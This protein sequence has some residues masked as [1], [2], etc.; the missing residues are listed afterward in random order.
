NRADGCS[1][2]Q[3]SQRHA[4]IATIAMLAMLIGCGLRRA[5]LLA[6]R[7]E[8]IQLREDHWVIADLVG[9]AQ[10]VRTVPIPTW[11]KNAIDEWTIAAG[12]THGVLFRAIKQSRARVG[13]RDV[14]QGALGCRPGGRGPRQHRQ[15]GTARSSAHVRETLSFGRRRTRSDSVPPGPRF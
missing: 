1:L 9:K 14:S 11:V 3:T 7:L 6:L 2:T 8:S 12:I 5:E 15:A 10:H 13:R 4:H